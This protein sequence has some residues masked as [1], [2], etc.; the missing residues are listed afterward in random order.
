MV[1]DDVGRSV[2]APAVR[3]NSACDSAL[4]AASESSCGLRPVRA[5]PLRSAGSRCIGERRP[6]TGSARPMSGWTREVEMVD[7]YREEI[8]CR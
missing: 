5:P 8:G 1:D 4:T 2:I 7:E 3:S 6:S